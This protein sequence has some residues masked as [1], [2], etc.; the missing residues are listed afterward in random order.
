VLLLWP[1]LLGPG[2]C[3]LPLHAGHFGRVRLLGI[4]AQL[5]ALLGRLGFQLPAN[6]VATHPLLSHSRRWAT[7]C[8]GAPAVR[9]PLDTLLQI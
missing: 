4:A 1:C 3:A 9:R 7:P 6:A 5:W 8:A 2:C